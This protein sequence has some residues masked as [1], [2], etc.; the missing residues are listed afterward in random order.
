MG[1]IM[2]AIICKYYRP[3]LYLYLLWLLGTSL[4]HD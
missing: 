4:L 2:T 3:S 1:H